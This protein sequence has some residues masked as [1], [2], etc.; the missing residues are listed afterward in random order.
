MS[1]IKFDVLNLSN[2]FNEITIKVKIINST[3]YNLDCIDVYKNIEK[4]I[5]KFYKK[6]I[7]L[8]L[9]LCDYKSIDNNHFEIQI[10]FDSFVNYKIINSLIDYLNYKYYINKHNYLFFELF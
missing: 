2:I 5:Y 6:I 4:R 7:C 1:N 3:T 10:F 9:C 8:S